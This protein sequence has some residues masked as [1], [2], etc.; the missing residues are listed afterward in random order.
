M[1][2]V[3]IDAMRTGAISIAT[4][5]LDTRNDTRNASPALDHVLDVPVL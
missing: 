3:A 4:G 5:L 2:D 1:L